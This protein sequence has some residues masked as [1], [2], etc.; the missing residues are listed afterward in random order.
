MIFPSMCCRSS[1]PICRSDSISIRLARSLPIS[2]K[3][4]CR[5]SRTTNLRRMCVTLQASLRSR[6]RKHRSKCS[7]VRCRKQH[8]SR[9]L[10]DRRLK[11]CWRNAMGKAR[12]E[13]RRLE[14]E[15][16]TEGISALVDVVSRDAPRI[17]QRTEVETALNGQSYEEA[18]W[19]K[20]SPAF[21]EAHN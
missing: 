16:L 10:W 12:R 13:R 9:C 3:R 15:R 17:V 11:Q 21:R 20:L 18:N 1:C 6:D 19:A 8:W 7:A 2:P 5:Y 4:E 14:R